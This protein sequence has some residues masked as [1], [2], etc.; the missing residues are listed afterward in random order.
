MIQK[1]VF[2]CSAL[3][4]V[5]VTIA[6]SEKPNIVLIMCDDMGYSDLGCYGGEIDT[7]NIDALAG[8]GIRFSHFKNTGRCCPSRASL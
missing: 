8:G 3:L 4:I 7:P 2:L 5:G 1:S 6:R